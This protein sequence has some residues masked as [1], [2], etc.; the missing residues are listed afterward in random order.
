MK[1]SKV[2]VLIVQNGL[3]VFSV[4]YI[5]VIGFLLLLAF[6]KH[7]NVVAGQYREENYFIL[8]IYTVG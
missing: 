7:V 8:K 3:S 4:Y 2:K 5:Y 6:K 1:T